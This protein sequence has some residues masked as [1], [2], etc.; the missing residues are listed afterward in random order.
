MA[1]DVA[2]D[3]LFVASPQSQSLV[4]RLMQPDPNQRLSIDEIWKHEWMKE[5]DDILSRR[6]LSLPQMH[7]LEDEIH[8]AFEEGTDSLHPCNH[9]Y[10]EQG[11]EDVLDLDYVSQQAW[12]SGVEAAHVSFDENRNDQLEAMRG[13]LR[14][15]L[16]TGN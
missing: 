4:E 5:N 6:D 9:H 13:F 11:L 2:F 1:G 15:W 16:D 14:N 8:R 7:H 3:E 12:L 10:F